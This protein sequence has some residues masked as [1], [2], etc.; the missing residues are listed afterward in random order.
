MAIKTAINNA[1]R[2]QR[3]LQLDIWTSQQYL[4]QRSRHTYKETARQL[5]IYCNIQGKKFMEHKVN[6]F[7]NLSKNNHIL[8][9]SACF[10]LHSSTCFPLKRNHHAY[11][12]KHP[13]VA[14]P[15]DLKLS[16][17]H[18]TFLQLGLSFCP[19]PK[20]A[21]PVKICNDNEQFSIRLRLH[22]YF[23]SNGDANQSPVHNLRRRISWS[24]PNGKNTIIDSFV[25]YTR[26]QYNN[27]ISNTPHGVKPNLPMQQ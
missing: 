11:S 6:K 25:N 10:L 22:E 9:S 16:P 21:D 3:L 1:Y 26:D 13:N 14:N 2:K 18:H 12:T 24:S 20:I 23:L 7:Y 8:E 17:E 4:E 5:D 15:S 27:F 19:T